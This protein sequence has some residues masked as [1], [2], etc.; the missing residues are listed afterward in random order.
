V[1]K[2]IETLYSHALPIKLYSFVQDGQPLGSLRVAPSL[3][4]GALITQ[5]SR[6]LD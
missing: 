1:S 6:F 2:D 5:G 4:S 3:L